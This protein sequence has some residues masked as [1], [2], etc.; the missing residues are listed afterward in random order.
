MKRYRAKR[1]SEIEL[2]GNTKLVHEGR[3]FEFNPDDF[4]E[5][6]EEN[7]IKLLELL[8]PEEGDWHQD[9][10]EVRITINELVETD[11]A[12]DMTFKALITNNGKHRVITQKEAR[13]MADII[14]RVYLISHAT[15]CRNCG[16][17][18]NVDST[19]P[20]KAERGK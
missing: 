20:A 5:V 13:E 10:N 2:N 17:K 19:P 8:E 7:E 12:A 9:D 3:L 11:F 16:E 4:E 18:Y 1:L 14:G 15:H 6:E